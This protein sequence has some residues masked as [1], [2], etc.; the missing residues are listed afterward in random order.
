MNNYISEQS[1]I[2]IAQ[3]L[4]RY[5]T[6]V[7]SKKGRVTKYG[8]YRFFNDTGKH[9][10][11][12][13]NNLSTDA[14]LFV[15]IHEIAH[16]VCYEYFQRKVSPHGDEWKKIFSKLLHQALDKRLFST[17]VV[18][19]LS[20]FAISPKSVV[21][22]NSK[23]HNLFFPE[24]IEDGQFL[25]ESIDFGAEFVFR[26]RVYRRLDKR[27]TRILCE[28]KSTKRKYLFSQSTLVTLYFE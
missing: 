1:Q 10:I 4:E 19:E 13:N 15:L 8:D 20:L 27:R 24:R 18:K 11:T 16:R 3:L 23:L 12:I 22:K 28:E 25:L 17:E 14:F 2:F 6:S 21:S 5:P 9:Q 7:V 26:K